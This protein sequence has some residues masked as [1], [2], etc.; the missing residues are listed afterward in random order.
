MAEITDSLTAEIG[1]LPVWAWGV[2]IAGGLGVGWLIQRQMNADGGGEAPEPSEPGDDLP[3]T[4][5]AI[6]L[7]GGQ[8]GAG[9][10]PILP[11]EQVGT[12]GPTTN[13]EWRAAGIDVL[14]RDGVAGTTADRALGRYLTG[15]QLTQAQAGH[16]DR[17]LAELGSPPEGTPPP[18]IAA[19][20][21]D[22]D[23]DP[24]PE[25]EPEPEP[26]PA[27]EPTPE[28]EPEPEPTPEPEPEPRRVKLSWKSPGSGKWYDRTMSIEQFRSPETQH[29]WEQLKVGAA[30]TR[31]KEL[32]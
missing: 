10:A 27:P 16:V 21:P 8:A 15:Q 5:G 26:Q 4:Q 24:E 25:P 30:M 14:M 3:P 2:A 20:E 13:P 12:G 28:P 22:P 6:G 29:W 7:P 9:R 23:P 17:V 18:R 11:E 1:P 19:D 31:V 32:P